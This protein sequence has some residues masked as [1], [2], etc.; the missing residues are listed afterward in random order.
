MNTDPDP[1]QHR[2]TDRVFAVEELESRRGGGSPREPAA[3]V[4]VYQVPHRF[5]LGSVLVVTTFFCV[6]LAV[7]R[8]FRMPAVLIGYIGL[9]ILAA[10]MMQIFIRKRPRGASVLVGAILLPAFTIGVL[11]YGRGVQYPEELLCTGFC[12]V[13]SGGVVGY[14]AGVLIAAVFMFMAMADEMISRKKSEDQ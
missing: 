2:L 12:S 7:M 6:L 9:Q 1:Q 11:V 3:P 13:I 10:G 5:G 4:R 14:V 8:F